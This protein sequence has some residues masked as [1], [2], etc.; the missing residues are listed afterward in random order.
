MHRLRQQDVASKATLYS[1]QNRLLA[2]A[3]HHGTL[4]IAA[5]VICTLH[6]GKRANSAL[7]KQY[8]AM[9]VVD[10][11]T[12]ELAWS[13]KRISSLAPVTAEDFE[14]QPF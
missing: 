8:A 3:K 11:L 10:P 7:L 2:Q 6:N 12:S 1:Q 5:V 4:R 14:G 13:V 9:T